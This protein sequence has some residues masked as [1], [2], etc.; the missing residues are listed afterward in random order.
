MSHTTST[1]GSSFRSELIHP[2]AGIRPHPQCSRLIA[3]FLI[4]S[5]WIVG[6]QHCARNPP[7]GRLARSMGRRVRPKLTAPCGKCTASIA[8]RRIKTRPTCPGKDAPLCHK[9]LLYLPAYSPD[10]NFIEQA[11][12]KIKGLLRKAEARSREALVDAI[13]QVI[14]A[15][16]AEDARGF[17]EPC[18]DGMAF[19][20][21]GERCRDHLTG[22]RG[23]EMTIARVTPSS[24]ALHALE[25]LCHHPLELGRSLFAGTQHCYPSPTTIRTLCQSAQS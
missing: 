8:P 24:N 17:F 23:Q 7:R 10:F 13:R 25:H 18:G 22:R 5:P 3:I 9:W 4:T 6:R 15:V 21:Y 2:G 20:H 19:N 16:S 1:T 14:S 11:F 12:S